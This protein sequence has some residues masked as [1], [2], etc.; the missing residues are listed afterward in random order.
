MAV[1]NR[2]VAWG[3]GGLELIA[4]AAGQQVVVDGLCL[5]SVST[6]RLSLLDGGGGAGTVRNSFNLAAGIPVVLPVPHDFTQSW[7]RT[8]T[9]KGLSI[10]CTVKCYV[11]ITIMYHKE[12]D[13]TGHIG[14]A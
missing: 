11:G 1:I 14:N 12:P 7:L 3:P 6:N 13:V 9:G 10:S 8:S 5:S 2:S 4:D